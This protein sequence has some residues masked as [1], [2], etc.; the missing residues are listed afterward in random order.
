MPDDY[1]I[2]EEQ[3]KFRVTEENGTLVQQIL[4]GT[5]KQTPTINS[6]TRT[7]EL[8]I[9]NEAKYDVEITKYETGTTKTLQNVKFLVKGKDLPEEGKTYVTDNNGKTTIKRLEPNEVYTIKEIYAKGYYVDETEFTVKVIRVDGRLQL[10]YGGR[11]A[12]EE[13]KIIEKIE[14]NSVVEIKHEDV[15]IPKYNL[16]LTKVGEKTGNLLEGAKFEIEGAGRDNINEKQYVTAQNGTLTIENLYENEEYILKEIL[17]PK[18]YKLKEEPVKFKAI[19]SNGNWTV[20]VL[21]GNFKETPIVESNK[22]KAKWEDELLFKLQKVDE[23]TGK[24]LQGAKYVIQEIDEDRKVIGY[25]KDA[26]GQEVGNL[27]T[28]EGTELRVLTTDEQG[29]IIAEIA[30]GLYQAT[31]V[32]SPYGYSLPEE[33]TQY[34]GVDAL[35]KEKKE[36]RTIWATAIG[37]EYSDIIRT[38]EQTKDGGY[39]AGGEF[40]SDSITL[41]NGQILTN[42]DKYHEDGILITK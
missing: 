37:G 30:P 15:N 38:V 6:E 36:G 29:M 2:S 41:D 9:E 8:E 14:E 28:I 10:E 17:A 32:Q 7:L 33:R 4:Q 18:G 24:P 16:E 31:E 35:A 11:T 12:K 20:E 23:E 21:E 42:K 13:P 39:I 1:V 25:A 27:E 40:N 22:I 34:F 26:S 3:V 19:L 5:V